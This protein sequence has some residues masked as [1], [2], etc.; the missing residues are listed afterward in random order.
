MATRSRRHDPQRLLILFLGIMGVLATALAWLGWRLLQ[1]DRALRDQQI[2]TR[3]ETTADAATNALHRRLTAVDETL[4]GVQARPAAERAGALGAAASTLPAGAVYAVV[5]DGHVDAFPADRLVYHPVLPPDAEP[6]PRTFQ[7]G[8]ALEFRA[9]DHPAAIRAYRTQTASPDPA[10]RAGALLRLARVLRKAGRDSAALPV[11]A[12]LARLERARIGE[13]PAGLVGAWGRLEVLHALGHEEALG[14]EAAAFRAAL[15]DGTWRMTRATWTFYREEVHRFL[16]APV[17]ADDEVDGDRVAL[18]DGVALLW[19][20]HTAAPAGERAAGRRTALAGDRPVL[21]VWRGD[22]ERTV[23]FVAAGRFVESAWLADVTAGLAADGM[24]LTLTDATGRPVSGAPADDAAQAIIRVMPQTGLPW[25]LQ[26][27]ALDPAAVLAGL[28]DRRR[29]MLAGLLVV[30]AVIGFGTYAVTRAVRREMEVARLQSEFVSAV[31]HEF[32]TPLTSMRQLTEMLAGGRVPSEQ[33]RAEYYAVIS[34]ES[35]R[36]HRLV[37]GLL[38]FGRME[39]GALEFTKDRLAI[40]GMVRDVVEEFR[41]E[42]GEAARGVTAHTAAPGVVVRGDREALTRVLWNLLDNALKYSPEQGA[43]E[44]AVT[45]NG[46][47]VAVSVRDH[48]SGMAADEVDRVFQKFV[49]GSASRALNVKGTGIGLAM[50]RHIVEAHH[51][52]IRV[53]SAP[54]AGSTFTVLLPMGETA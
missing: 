6:P 24:A 40:D 25:N 19:D 9:R 16:P 27:A 7:R 14:E 53:E 48:G 34:R 21:L 47:R 33:R 38:D 10:T 2:R 46:A 44:V 41:A 22:G 28:G 18:A 54:G 8:E 30:A 23:G 17:S 49:R 37:E 20:V 11:Y 5:T 1:Q 29:L 12:E 32:R 31:S 13:L 36:L 15:A 50:V 3:L 4:A 39:A 43:V 42:R 35:E 26:V 45:P 51:G 52:E